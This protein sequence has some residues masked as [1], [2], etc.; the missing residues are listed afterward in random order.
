MTVSRQS[1]RSK[2]PATI[3]SAIATPVIFAHRQHF[4]IIVMSRIFAVVWNPYSEP[5]GF[6]LLCWR[7]SDMPI[8]VEQIKIP[9]PTLSTVTLFPTRNA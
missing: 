8:P 3:S 4:G 6:R 5:L 2:M 7:Q 1:L 9:H